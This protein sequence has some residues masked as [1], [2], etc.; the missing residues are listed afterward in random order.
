MYIVS[1]REK[2]VQ[3]I[4]KALLKVGIKIDPEKYNKCSSNFFVECNLYIHVQ[5]FKNDTHAK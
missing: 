4:Q 5:I 2:Y 1:L 3:A